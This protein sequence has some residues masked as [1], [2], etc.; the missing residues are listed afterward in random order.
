MEGE[1]ARVAR[2]DGER[3][4]LGQLQRSAAAATRTAGQ[5]Q[6]EAQFEALPGLIFCHFQVQEPPRNH[7]LQCQDPK[8]ATLGMMQKPN[9]K[10]T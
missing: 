8:L 6:A 3:A 5:A 10:K 9:M 2:D 7:D 4:A 1:K